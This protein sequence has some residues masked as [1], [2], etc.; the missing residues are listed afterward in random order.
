MAAIATSTVRR[1]IKGWNL[2]IMHDDK[3]RPIIFNP[4]IESYRRELY[5]TSYV[6]KL[7]NT[8]N[9]KVYI[10]FHTE[11]DDLYY[12]SA[13]DPDFKSI[14]ASNIPGILDYEI[15]FWG[16]EKECRG[17]EYDLLKKFKH[18]KSNPKCYNRSYGQKGVK[19]LDIDLV[20]TLQLEIDDTREFQNNII[21]SILTD[22]SFSIEEIDLSTLIEF[23]KLQTREL[24]I[25][26]DNYNY[27][28]SMVENRVKRRYG[29][30]QE[31]YDMPVLLK[32]IWLKNPD[33][34]EIDFFD[35]I[36]IS[37]N[38]T[39]TVFFDLASS[40]K[41]LYF[42]LTY[43][44]KCLVIES[45]VTEDMQE[46]EV[47]MLSN[48]LNRVNGGGK[49]FSTGDALLECKKFHVEGF[50]YRTPQMKQRW[51]EMGLTRGQVDG[52]IKKMD[53]HIKRDKEIGN[54]YIVHD[55]TSNN[56]KN[57]IDNKVKIFKQDPNKFVK[58]MS[59]GNPSLYRLI[60][61]YMGEQERRVANG[62]PIQ[63]EIQIV[64]YHPT[65]DA[66]DN[67]NNKLRKQYLRPLNT[68][69][70]YTVDTGVTHYFSPSEFNQLDGLFKMPKVSIEVLPIKTRAIK[71]TKSRTLAVA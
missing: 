34:N 21:K 63:N 30:D 8:Q 49:K 57:I 27:V 16:S 11:G 33:T 28:K 56:G 9:G 55:Y 3:L 25:D 59:S 71:R 14:L 66:E 46:A 61:E 20:K 24:E 43:K 50:T 69:T 36:L 5:H 54:G 15:V 18:I 62:N 45:D 12:S 10:G 37:G 7:T 70:N 51:L 60:D 58:A 32:D 35:Y 17:I 19:P 26:S 47:Y 6:Y 53:E 22:T 13:T 29:K 67:W 40:S 68:S 64:L 39:R 38:H 23:P 48:N 44:L 4:P 52:V 65:F 31:Q 1:K 41:N 2:G 42:D